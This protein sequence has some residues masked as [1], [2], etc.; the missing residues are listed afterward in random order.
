MLKRVSV[1]TYK[2]SILFYGHFDIGIDSF[3]IVELNIPLGPVII[4][5]LGVGGA[6]FLVKDSKI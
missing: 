4:Y 5:R 6:W 1:V 3:K 2:F